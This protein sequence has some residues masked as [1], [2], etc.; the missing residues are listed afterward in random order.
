MHSVTGYPCDAEWNLTDQAGIS[1]HQALASTVSANA[2]NAR[3][4]HA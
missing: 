1:P 3:P 2:H 4:R